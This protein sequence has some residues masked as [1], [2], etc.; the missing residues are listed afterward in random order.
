M[1]M[2]LYVFIDHAAP[3]V[4]EWQQA[5]DEKQLPVEL[6][7]VT[8]LAKLNGFFPMTLR[9]KKAGFEYLIENMDDLSSL[10]PEIHGAKLK[11]RT[12]LSLSYGGMLGCASAFYSAAAL[13]AKFNGRAFDTEGGK[14]LGYAE[15]RKTAD[16]CYALADKK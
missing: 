4:V 8:D 7:K 10:Y 5:L 2:D 9:G 16:Q 15:L 14:F 11:E 12:A 6:G 3:T 13:V 1:S